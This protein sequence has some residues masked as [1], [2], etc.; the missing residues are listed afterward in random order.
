MKT[1]LSVLKKMTGSVIFSLSNEYQWHGKKSKPDFSALCWTLNYLWILQALIMLQLTP[2][3]QGNKQFPLSQDKKRGSQVKWVA[4]SSLGFEES[5]LEHLPV[6]HHWNICWDGGAFTDG[7]RCCLRSVGF[8]IFPSLQTPKCFPCSSK[9]PR[10]SS[11]LSPLTGSS[12]GAHGL[13]AAL[14]VRAKEPGQA[15]PG[16]EEAHLVVLIDGAEDHLGSILGNLELSV[17]DRGPVVHDHHDVLG[18][19]ANGRDIDGPEGG[20]KPKPLSPGTLSLPLK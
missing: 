20:T 19:R 4:Q 11:R 9:V 18:L 6:D 8:H 5:R 7:S 16:L 13:G 15:A 17:C 1:W 3:L 14:C 12:A 2:V 10:V